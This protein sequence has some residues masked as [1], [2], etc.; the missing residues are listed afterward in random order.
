MVIRLK[1]AKAP[2]VASSVWT[3]R[4]HQAMALHATSPHGSEH[5]ERV[6]ARSL[7]SYLP[8]VSPSTTEASRNSCLTRSPDVQ[9]AVECVPEAPSEARQTATSEHLQPRSFE[10]LLLCL[11]LKALIWGFQHR[12]RPSQRKNTKTTRR[13]LRQPLLSETPPSSNLTNG[14][15]V[16]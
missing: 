9:F 3:P 8:A 14:R 11:Y 2:T 13:S 6:S 16:R 15:D 1:A 12:L 4:S 7:C 10:C 5:T